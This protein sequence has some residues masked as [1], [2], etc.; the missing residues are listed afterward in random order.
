MPCF[1]RVGVDGTGEIRWFE[2][3]SGESDGTGKDGVGEDWSYVAEVGEVVEKKDGRHSVTRRTTSCCKLYVFCEP[4]SI[5]VIAIIT[6]R[7]REFS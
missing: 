4:M 1:F 3:S 2:W 5:T 7:R 6:D